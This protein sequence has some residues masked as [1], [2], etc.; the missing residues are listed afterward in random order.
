MVS[1]KH[2]D[3]NADEVCRKECRST[4]ENTKAFTEIHALCRK[5][6]PI[7]VCILTQI[8]K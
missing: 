8:L 1:L 7:R 4:S 5:T 6:F 2:Y 3:R